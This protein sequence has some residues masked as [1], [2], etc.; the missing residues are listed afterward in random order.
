MYTATLREIDAGLPYLRSQELESGYQGVYPKR[1]K[2]AAKAFRKKY[3]GT[4]PNPREAARAVVRAWYRT[5][6]PDWPTVFEGRH[7]V[8]W[9]VSPTRSA[10]PSTA[11]KYDPETRQW[12]TV[13]LPRGGYLVRVWEFGSRRVVFP[14]LSRCSCFADRESGIAGYRQWAYQTHG[15]FAPI[16]LRWKAAP[17]SPSR[18]TMTA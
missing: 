9:Q 5:Y 11:A 13:E 16:V 3:I 18:M 1:R 17:G 2:W 15:M 6:G 7:R 10:G 4:F 8:A 14:H 12:Y